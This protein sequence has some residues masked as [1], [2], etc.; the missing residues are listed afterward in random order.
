MNP[1]RPPKPTDSARPD[2]AR[3]RVGALVRQR[4]LSLRWSLQ[5]LADEVGCAKG[6]LSEVETGRRAAPGEAVLRRI[7][8]SM[9][10]ARGSLTAAGGLERGLAAGGEIV[11]RE[12]SRLRD[13]GDAAARLATVF[14]EKA[15]QGP[16][17][18]DAA[19]ASGELRRL[20]ERLAPMDGAESG[21][22]ADAARGARSGASASRGSAPGGGRMGAAAP[23]PGVGPGAL[24]DLS[25]WLPVEVPLINKVA[26]GYP[27]EF[28]DLSYPARIADEYVRCPDVRDPDAFAARVVG[29]SMAP[30]Y[31]EGDVVVFSPAKEVESGD[32]CFARL[33]RDHETTFKRVYFERGGDGE[34]LIRL[35]PINNAYPPRVLPR[36]D[37]AGLYAAV[38]AIRRVGTPG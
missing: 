17:A 18:L 11:E 22:G 21:D 30:E 24:G 15:A 28:T 12:L 31:R 8:E 33:E 5:R 10:M 7:E 27:R 4:R 37:V 23:N 6:Y 26:A 36:E 3:P 16:G 32:D 14:R 38:A 1:E 35:Q 2:A 20:I 13:R 9:M 34:E 29:D 19:Y 25:R